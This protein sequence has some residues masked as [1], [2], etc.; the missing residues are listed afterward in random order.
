MFPRGRWRQYRSATERAEAKSP[1]TALVWEDSNGVQEQLGQDK[2]ATEDVVKSLLRSPAR[3]LWVMFLVRIYESAPLACPHCGADMGIP[4]F[5]RDDVSVRRILA[6]IGEPTDYQRPL[7]VSMCSSKL[8]EVLV[9]PP[10]VPGA[11]VNRC[12]TSVGRVRGGGTI[13]AKNGAVVT[14]EMYS[15]RVPI[16]RISQLSFSTNHLT[17]WLPTSA[18]EPMLT[19]LIT[20]VKKLEQP[21]GAFRHSSLVSSQDPER[22]LR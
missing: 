12:F 20:E 1:V 21:R 19:T 6:H 5:V 22:R 18:F 7:S 9:A 4:A 3:Y 11:L 16:P 14:T 15:R 8:C 10:A 17:F 2:G 13:G